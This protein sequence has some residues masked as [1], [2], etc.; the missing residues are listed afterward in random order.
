MKP[1]WS[2]DTPQVYLDK[3]YTY[4]YLSNSY[5]VLEIVT[6]FL[7]LL[8]IGNY[9]WTWW[10]R[11]NLSLLQKIGEAPMSTLQNYAVACQLGREP[12]MNFISSTL[13]TQDRP[14]IVMRIT[15]ALCSTCLTFVAWEG[16]R[17]P[18]FGLYYPICSVITV[19][20]SKNRELIIEGFGKKVQNL[21]K[22]L[23]FLFNCQ[24]PLRIFIAITWWTQWFGFSRYKFMSRAQDLPQF[25]TV[26]KEFAPSIFLLVELL[27]FDTTV[28]FCGVWAPIYAG[29]SCVAAVFYDLI[30]EPPQAFVTVPEAP[31]RCLPQLWIW[32]VG[33]IIAHQF[34]AA[35]CVL[36]A[37]VFKRLNVIG[38]RWTTRQQ[39]IVNFRKRQVFNRE[40]GDRIPEERKTTLKHSYKDFGRHEKR[41]T[42]LPKRQT[43]A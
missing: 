31:A 9:V 11:K 2:N 1:G 12:A 8:S 10:I 34:L 15:L 25:I 39:C 43:D 30:H 26:S 22:L 38:D 20:V 6:W 7:V 3:G 35:L 14:M 21:N 23:S 24:A 17:S 16:I 28:P 27:W 19:Y 5:L 41:K 33:I 13:V 4:E 29:M 42:V 18:F 37:F 32:T 36:K 40:V